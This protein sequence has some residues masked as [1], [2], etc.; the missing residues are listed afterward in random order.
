MV[1][2]IEKY[3]GIY[4]AMHCNTEEKANAFLTF[5]LNTGHPL[6]KSHKENIEDNNN[7]S[8]YKEKTCYAFNDHTYCYI[9]Y[10]FDKGSL[11]LEFDD[12]EWPN[13]EEAVIDCAK[14]DSLL[15]E[16]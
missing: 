7:Y 10:F 15:A 12:F 5:L 13:F 14:I 2:E 11:V 16:M 9:D 8:R 3:H 1:F 6:W 4:D